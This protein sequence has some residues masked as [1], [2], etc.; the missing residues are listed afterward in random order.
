MDTIAGSRTKAVSAGLKAQTN[1]PKGYAVYMSAGSDHTGL[2]RADDTSYTQCINSIE[3]DG[4]LTDNTWGFHTDL[5]DPTKPEETTSGWQGVQ[6]KANA[7]RV[8]VRDHAS[9]DFESDIAGDGGEHIDLWFGVKASGGLSSGAY[10][11]TVLY[12]VVSEAADMEDILLSS[13]STNNFAGGD[14]LTITTPLMTSIDLTQPG[15]KPTV[16]IGSKTCEITKIGLNKDTGLIEIDCKTPAMTAGTYTVTVSFPKFG[17]IYND[18]TAQFTYGATGEQTIASVTPNELQNY[19]T[20]G[21]NVSTNTTLT[22]VTNLQYSSALTPDSDVSVSV[23]GTKCGSIAASTVSESDKRLQLTCTAPVLGSAGSQT[24]VV[25]VPGYGVGDLTAASTEADKVTYSVTGSKTI[26][27]LS[28]TSLKAGETVSNFYIDTGLTYAGTPTGI[29]MN[30]TNA[31]TCT[32]TWTGSQNGSNLRLTCPS[33]T[34]T[35]STGAKSFSMKVGNYG[36]YGDAII[37]GTTLNVTNPSYTYTLQFN[38]GGWTGFSNLPSTITETS[39]NTSYEITVPATDVP[40]RSGYVFLG[41]SE[42]SGATSGTYNNIEPVKSPLLLPITPRPSMPCGLRS[43][44]ATCRTSILLSALRWP[45]ILP[46]TS[47]TAAT[48]LTAPTA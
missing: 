2:C 47:W 20:G 48:P 18:L 22:I 46:L 32:G 41:W 24:V 33:F 7:S 5:T 39:T 30:N 37:S 3:R 6:L 23:G 11:N 25:S 27:G 15:W 4:N 36:T 17:D 8:A 28:H 29:E 45:R 13:D 31:G 12:T 26:T 43:R 9:D 19:L 44:T 1:S 10:T 38:N 42:T 40:L 16:T 14:T 21:P 35:S 34:A